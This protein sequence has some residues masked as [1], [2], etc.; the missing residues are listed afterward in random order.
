[1]STILKGL[2]GVQCYLDDVSV[3]GKTVEEHDK[4]LNAA[5]QCLEAAGLKLNFDKCQIRQT[6]L[7]FLGHAILA[8]GLQLDD[9]LVTAVSHAPPPT[10]IAS[11]SSFLGLTL[12]YSKFIPNYS[13][14]VKPFKALNRGSASFTWTP[15]AQT[16]FERVK[17]LLI[18]NPALTLFDPELHTIVTTDA[19]NYGLGAV[20][21][22]M[23]LDGF[24]KTVAFASHKLTQA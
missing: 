12:W 13:A 18:N 24:K 4:N 1:M 14:V 23:H 11:L 19:S 21:N 6:E 9:S 5:I 15:E 2:A 22:Q 20:L 17:D 7:S 8:K 3:S 16:G 10:D